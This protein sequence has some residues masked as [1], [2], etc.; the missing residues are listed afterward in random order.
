M[1]PRW[2]QPQKSTPLPGYESEGCYTEVRAFTKAEREQLVDDSQD[3]LVLSGADA[4]HRSGKVKTS[5]ARINAFT[6]NTCIL[7]FRW[8]VGT[9]EELPESTPAGMNDGEWTTTRA[10]VAKAENGFIDKKALTKEELRVLYMF[11]DKDLEGHVD[12]LIDEINSS[13]AD[14][15]QAPNPG[16]L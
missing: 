9:P 3:G 13:A 15:G 5:V 6:W 8:P 16:G 14:G 10:L 11:A 7:G 4:E 2:K 12:A 1:R